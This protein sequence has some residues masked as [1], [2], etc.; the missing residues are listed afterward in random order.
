MGI[1]SAGASVKRSGSL[2]ASAHPVT[3]AKGTRP[4]WATFLPEARMRQA[5]P[6]LNGDELGA[7][8]VPR[9]EGCWIDKCVCVFGFAIA[10][11]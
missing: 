3:L 8:T 6:S 7:V 9:G 5:A 1:A 4:N 10:D 11:L 2:A